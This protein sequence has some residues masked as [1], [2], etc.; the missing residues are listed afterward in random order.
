M[1]APIEHVSEG[2]TPLA[3]NEGFFLKHPVGAMPV[4]SGIDEPELENIRRAVVRVICW[5]AR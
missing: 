4:S 1:G 5:R 2:P 3:I